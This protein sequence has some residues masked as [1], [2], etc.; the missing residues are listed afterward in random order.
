MSHKK[1][2]EGHQEKG[3]QQEAADA[4]WAATVSMHVK[5]GKMQV[6]LNQDSVES[7]IP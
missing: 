4:A 2:P 5:E 7:I 6:Y 1:G 3:Q